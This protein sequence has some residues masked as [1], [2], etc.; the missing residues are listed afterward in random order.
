VVPTRDPEAPEE[1]PAALEPGAS[2]GARFASAVAARLAARAREEATRDED[3]TARKMDDFDAF[4]ATLA[5]KKQE[6]S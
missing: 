6:R 2:T 1:D 4:R 3:A 5:R